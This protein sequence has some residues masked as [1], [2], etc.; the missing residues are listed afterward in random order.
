MRKN[1]KNTLAAYTELN[2]LDEDE[3]ITRAQNGDTHAFNPLIRKYQQRI[4]NLIYRRIQNHEAAE[5]ICQEV[6]LKA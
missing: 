4:Y 5:D 1:M 2:H 3:L 6:F